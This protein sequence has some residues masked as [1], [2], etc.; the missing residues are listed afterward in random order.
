MDVPGQG[1]FTAYADGRL[2]AVFSDRTILHVNGAR[3]H[4]KARESGGKRSLL[5][6]H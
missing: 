2:R 3:T 4:A 5:H 1:V 6:L